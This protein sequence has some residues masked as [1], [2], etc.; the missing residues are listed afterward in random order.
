MRAITGRG[1][2]SSIAGVAGV[3]ATVVVAVLVI[4]C[5]PKT[6][7]SSGTYHDAKYGFSLRPDP[8]YSLYYQGPDQTN[9]GRYEVTW[10]KKSDLP[11]QCWSRVTV[12]VGEHA[13]GKREIS[14]GLNEIFVNWRAAVEQ[15][16]PGARPIGVRRTEVGGFSAVAF[17]CDYATQGHAMRAEAITFE[18]GSHVFIIASFSPRDSWTQDLPHLT[19]F[20]SS[21]QMPPGL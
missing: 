21:F 19:E 13:A 11:S 8:G 9:P 2:R 1:R 20:V 6:G 4:G 3:A 17:D 14:R 12:A 5:S 18:T 16:R 10:V 7:A 15:Y